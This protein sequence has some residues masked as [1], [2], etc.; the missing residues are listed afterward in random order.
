MKYLQVLGAPRTLGPWTLSTIVNR[1]WR[2][3]WCWSWEDWQW[4]CCWSL[5]PWRCLRLRQR[6]IVGLRWVTVV[7]WVMWATP[8]WSS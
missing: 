4:S 6:V 8:N 7:M 5:R 1:L 3:C 2:Y